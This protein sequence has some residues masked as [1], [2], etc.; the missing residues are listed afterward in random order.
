MLL[1]I[2]SYSKA[3]NGAAPILQRTLTD[4]NESKDC[5]SFR[6]LGGGSRVSCD[7]VGKHCRSEEE[8]NT[9]IAPYMDE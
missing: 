5:G 8:W 1:S 7:V 4:I 9:L 3:E 2:S 6:Q